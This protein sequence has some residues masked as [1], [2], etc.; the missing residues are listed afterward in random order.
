MRT[1][2]NPYNLPPYVKPDKRLI[3]ILG[4]YK[5][6]IFSN[7]IGKTFYIILKGKEEII[8]KREGKLNVIHKGLTQKELGKKLGRSQPTIND[9]LYILTKFG[10]VLEKKKRGDPK[11]YSANINRLVSFLTT[12]LLY[13]PLGIPL[14]KLLKDGRQ[15]LDENLDKFIPEYLIGLATLYFQY[16][17]LDMR[18]QRIYRISIQTP[19]TVIHKRKIN[20]KVDFEGTTYPTIRE[21]L[22]NFGNFVLQNYRELMKYTRKKKNRTLLTK[23]YNFFKKECYGL[24]L[25]EEFAEKYNELSF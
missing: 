24:T 1:K 10:V 14:K 4:K 22:F 20:A 13:E 11:E 5:D 16:A 6:P 18:G 7:E 17:N 3:K 23:L 15:H 25:S 8:G 19:R 2:E 9:Q 21:L 12:W